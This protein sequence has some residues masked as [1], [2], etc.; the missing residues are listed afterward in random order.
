MDAL[1]IQEENEVEYSSQN[2]GVMHACG[3][4]AHVAM[5]L[6]AAR[7]LKDRL[8][9]G[10]VRF[11]FQPA[12][13]VGDDE[14]IS[15]AVRMIEDGAAEGVHAMLAL[16][17][18]VH[19]DVGRVTVDD[20]HSSA[21][22]DTFY[23][24]IRGK[25]GHGA[26]PHRVIDPIHISAAVIQAM[27][28]IV[29]RR[30]HPFEPAVVSI[31]TIHAGQASNVIPD[32]VKISGTLRFLNDAV[33]KVLHEEVRRS[34]E[35]ARTMGGD[36][37]LELEIGYPPMFNHPGMT[38]YIRET[39]A[40]L[41]GDASIG[42]PDREMGAEDFGFFTADAPGAMFYLGAR[43]PGDERTPH[44]PRFDIDEDCL[45]IGSA[46]LAATALRYLQQAG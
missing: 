33:Q 11:I 38:K 8:Q 26:F 15:G 40:A 32:E 16:H 36:Y 24:T 9:D 39:G 43:K 45:P 10:A 25:G 13:E 1:P 46:M 14:G 28:S 21:G 3:H 23:A 19:D 12:E 37:E 30:L 17:V 41:L 18:D 35:T 29:S 31:C 6:G 44:H 22:V 27:N 5:A 42:I 34:L 4:D 20:G 7:L 2:P